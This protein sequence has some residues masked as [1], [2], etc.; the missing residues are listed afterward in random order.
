MPLDQRI[1]RLAHQIADGYKSPYEKAKAVERYLKTSYKYSLD[2]KPTEGDPLAEF[3]FD[4]K[5]GFCEYFATAMAIMLRTLDIPTRVVN[6]FQ[7]GEYNEISDF[8]TVRERDA[9]S[10]VEV[11]FPGN[12]A[13]VE[14][15][16]TPSAGINDYSNGGLAARIRQ[17]MD[18][19][20][21][22]WMDYVVTLDRNEQASIMVALQYRL[23][24]VRETVLSAYVSFRYW[25]MNQVRSLLL[26][27]SWTAGQL[28]GLVL[29]GCCL[30][31][32]LFGLYALWSYLSTRRLPLSVRSSWW[33]R[34]FILP[35][36]RRKKDARA[37]AVMF[38]EQMLSIMSNKGLVKQPDETPLEFAQ[39][40]SGIIQVRHLTEIYNKVRFGGESLGDVDRHVVGRLLSELKQILRRKKVA[41]QSELAANNQEL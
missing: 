1:A 34:L 20:E 10:W 30:I 2:V 22:F 36:W 5:A 16:P 8:Y 26:E 21:A 4:T 32:T 35:S 13:W 37:S 19:A 7:M 31:L 39:A 24:M 17:L 23:R 40:N 41:R 28:I 3:L 18:S 15:D 11:Y 38:Y 27:R 9:H 29:R 6:G 25:L 33:R 12:S 14:F